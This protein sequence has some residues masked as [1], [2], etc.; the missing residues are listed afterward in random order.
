MHVPQD[1]MWRE[2]LKTF[3]IFG[4]TK[5]GLSSRKN[6]VLAI[7][8]FCFYLTNVVQSLD[9]KDSSRKL[10]TNYAISFCFIYI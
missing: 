7:V 9:L 2:I 10:Q 6:L 8:A 1:S 5:Q 4:W 3:W